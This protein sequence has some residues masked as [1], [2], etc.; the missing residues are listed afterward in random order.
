MRPPTQTAVKACGQQ[1]MMLLVPSVPHN[2]RSLP[3]HP[4]SDKCDLQLVEVVSLLAFVK[5]S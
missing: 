2:V 5:Y 4:R 3:F 1:R